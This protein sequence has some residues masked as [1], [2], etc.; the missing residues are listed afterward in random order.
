MDEQGVFELSRKEIDCLKKSLNGWA[1]LTIG[2]LTLFYPRKNQ[3]KR[4][5]D[6]NVEWTPRGPPHGSDMLVDRVSTSLLTHRERI[7]SMPLD[8]TKLCS[9]NRCERL[10]NLGISQQVIC[11]KRIPMGCELTSLQRIAPA[12]PFAGTRER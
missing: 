8:Q 6:L 12:V 5:F 3:D 4:G 10:R 7:H 11:C 2:L 9:P 1:D